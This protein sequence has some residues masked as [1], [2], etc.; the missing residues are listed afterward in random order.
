MEELDRYYEKSILG[1]F[2]MMKS[3]CSNMF[4]G[5]KHNIRDCKKRKR[6]LDERHNYSSIVKFL[7]NRK[8]IIEAF[9]FFKRNSG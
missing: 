4:F 2:K 9:L 6:K 1:F 7:K 8:H 5:C 3:L